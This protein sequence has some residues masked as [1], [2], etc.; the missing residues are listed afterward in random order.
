MPAVVIV[1]TLGIICLLRAAPSRF[2]RNLD[3]DHLVRAQAE[4]FRTISAHVGRRLGLDGIADGEPRPADPSLH[5]HEWIERFA[6]GPDGFD[7]GA[8]RRE[9]ARQLGPRWTGYANAEPHV[10]C[11]FAAF[12]LH[13]SRDRTGAIALLGTLAESLSGGE[14]PL[15]FPERAVAAA[16]AALRDPNVTQPCAEVADGHAYTMPALMTVLCHA[17]RR[18]GVLAPAQFNFLKLDG[19]ASL[20]RAALARLSGRKQSLISGRCRTH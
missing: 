13:A 18:A 5:D 11:L 17:R 1:A 16:D 12:V 10:R 2:C 15:M 6:T 3:L 20:V 19:S 7:E 8:A 4:V 9:L 14:P